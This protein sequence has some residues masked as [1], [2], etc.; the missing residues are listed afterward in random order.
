MPPLSLVP[1]LGAILS[2]V[3]TIVVLCVQR[4]TLRAT[5]H[6]RRKIL[7]PSPKDRI[8][9]TPKGAKAKAAA[10]PKVEGNGRWA[11]IRQ[12][13]YGGVLVSCR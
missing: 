9:K 4:H 7:R 1:S 6:G 8:E 3:F 11:G 2:A 5:L 10:K 12:E 13:Y